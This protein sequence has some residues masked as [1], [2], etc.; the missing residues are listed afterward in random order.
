MIIFHTHMALEG[1]NWDKGYWL[2]WIWDKGY[3]PWIWDIQIDEFGIFCQQMKMGYSIIENGIF[4][5]FISLSFCSQE[6]VKSNTRGSKIYFFLGGEPPNPPTKSL[7]IKVLSKWNPLVSN[8]EQLHEFINVI[9]LAW[10][11]MMII[12]EQNVK[13]FIV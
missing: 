10:L 7:L 9:V 3:W 5:S 11:I 6:R 8:H 2:F 12:I 4:F 1:V 13:G